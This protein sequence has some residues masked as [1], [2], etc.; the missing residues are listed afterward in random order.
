MIYYSNINNAILYSVNRKEKITEKRN[1]LCPE[2]EYLQVSCKMLSRGE[3]FKPHKHLPLERKT[4]TTH[5]TWIIIEGR[6]KA[7]LYDIDNLIYR[8][9]I[10]D[11]G[12]CLVVF[13]AGHSM[14]V[15]EPNTILYEV[16][17]GPYYGQK[18]DKVFIHDNKTI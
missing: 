12:D 14:E 5:E 4:L 3:S 11:P 8:E 1:D 9:E 17:N 6:V 7:K 18:L 10:L 16:K 15:L 2:T 13:N